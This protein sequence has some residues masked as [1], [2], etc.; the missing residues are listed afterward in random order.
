[1]LCAVF[2]N[3]REAEKSAASDKSGDMRSDCYGCRAGIWNDI[4][5]GA[6]D[7]CLGLQRYGV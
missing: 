1:M 3:S 4:Q 6:E 5:Y 7:E 2:D